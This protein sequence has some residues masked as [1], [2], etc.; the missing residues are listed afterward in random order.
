M[1]QLAVR[2]DNR[3]VAAYSIICASVALHL[4]LH[5]AEAKRKGNFATPHWY[6]ASHLIF[7][8]AQLCSSARGLLLAM[9]HQRWIGC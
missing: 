4:L 6:R 9:R 8:E 1:T 7:G 3:R 5:V 2:W